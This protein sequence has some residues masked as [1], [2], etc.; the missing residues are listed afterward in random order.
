MTVRTGLRRP[1]HPRAIGAADQIADCGH[2]VK[3]RR[4]RVDSC[5]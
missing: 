1:R 4:R 2:A 5:A 3:G